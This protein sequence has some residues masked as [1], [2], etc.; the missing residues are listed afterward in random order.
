MKAVFLFFILLFI[1]TV[2]FS[3][4]FMYQDNAGK[5]YGVSSIDQVPLEYKNQIEGIKSD[6]PL[7][8]AKNEVSNICQPPS[9]AD[10]GTISGRLY[11]ITKGGDVKPALKVSIFILRDY[12]TDVEQKDLNIIKKKIDQFA[13]YKFG[14]ED[15]YNDIIQLEKDRVILCP[16]CVF[17]VATDLNGNFIFHGLPDG[18]YELYCMGQAGANEAI[19]LQSFTISK[20]N[21]SIFIDG[22][23]P[24]AS[25]LNL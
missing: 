24:V 18:N 21:P 10:K 13:N 4:V 12:G 6:D 19:W 25:F 23:V 14:F 20:S 2:C 11:L 7:E 3:E 1:P 9:D 22:G 8:K 15:I 17:T 5:W 16:Y